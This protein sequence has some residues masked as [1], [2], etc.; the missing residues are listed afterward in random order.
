MGFDV[1][2]Y[3]EE[4][5]IG[6]RVIL[7]LVVIILLCATIVNAAPAGFRDLG[8]AVPITES[9]GL[10]VFKD[11]A[12]RNLAL[13]LTMDES[14]RGYLLIVDIDRGK[15]DQVFYP[16]GVKKAPAYA[17]M[18]S[19]KGRFY[20]GSGSQLLEFDIVNRRFLYHGIPDPR[21]KDI[22]GEAIAEGPDGLIYVGTHPDCHL[23]SFNPDT[24]AI[25]DHGQMDPKE[26]YPT[27]LIFDSTGWLYAGIGTARCNIVA[28]NPKTGELRRI[29]DENERKQGTAAVFLGSDG[30]AYGIANNQ[31]YRMFQGKSEKI[32]E[33]VAAKKASTGAIDWRKESV[34]LADGR[35]VKLDLRNAYI[36]VSTDG[37][38]TSRMPIKFKSGGAQVTS[39]IVGP[40][41]YIYGS[42][43]HPMHL[44]R[45][46][47]LT[48]QLNDLGPVN[49]VGGG[50]FSAMAVQ[51]QYLAAASYPYGIF[52]IFNTKEPFNGGYSS[53]PNPWEAAIWSRDIARPRACIPHP[54]GR[55][56]LMA[57]FGSYG[58]TGG[59]LGMY[60]LLARKAT[61]ITQADLIPGESTI[62][63]RILPN[64]DVIGGTSIEAPGGGHV[65]AA[66]ATLYILDWKTRK[67]VFKT[68][69]L[70][71][72]REIIS[73]EIGP[74][75]LVYGLGS[76]SKFFVFDP[77]TRRVVHRNNLDISRYGDVPRQAL[78]IADGEL[79]AAM[80]K[81]LIRV[82]P[83][84]FQ[85]TKIINMPPGVTTAAVYAVGRLYFACGA[86]LWSYDLKP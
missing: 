48:D 68:H 73:L 79:Y 17:S 69:P 54:D 15:V 37:S 35:G 78:V 22:I 30:K 32:E 13:I 43:A 57:G 63:M 16:E 58:F 33:A 61:L 50:N 34:K 66:Q 21:A 55:T 70:P 53:P 27:Y 76:G 38:K 31:Y 45:Y 60:D 3:A 9:R 6:M 67:L 26:E 65:S 11:A 85:L 7:S 20:I 39:L 51:G 74:D 75:G 4:W 82:E 29:L 40:D 1:S 23:I 46:Y 49:R 44:F 2:S 77:N 71:G 18:V 28:F 14:E 83:K 64:G 10:A 41:G 47:A 80:T 42:S 86:H 25:K 36:E 62:S 24:K 84:T 56:V 12:D 8:V 72:M 5:P 19:K 52:H 59:G 81:T